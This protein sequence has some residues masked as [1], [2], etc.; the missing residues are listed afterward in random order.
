[1]TALSSLLDRATAR[2]PDRHA[3]RLDDP[4]LTCAHLRV[5]DRRMAT[6]LASHAIAAGGRVEI[7]LPNGPAFP[8]SFYGALACWPGRPPAPP[9]CIMPAPARRR[10]CMSA[11]RRAV[12][13]RSSYRRPPSP[14]PATTGNQPYIHTSPGL[15]STSSMRWS[16]G[17]IAPVRHAW[18]RDVPLTPL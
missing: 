12:I 4:V 5:A 10:P 9:G 2:H 6:P 8:V 14:V 3:L 17:P 1:M 11:S 15:R 13:R 16:G 7:M 18:W